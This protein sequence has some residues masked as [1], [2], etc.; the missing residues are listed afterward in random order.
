MSMGRCCTLAESTELGVYFN[1]WLWH[2][3]T[4]MNKEQNMIFYTDDVW[5]NLEVSGKACVDLL[6]AGIMSIDNYI[7]QLHREAKDFGVLLS[8]KR[9]DSK[10]L[11]DRL[12]VYLRK[13]RS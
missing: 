1:L 13:N 9:T 3:E 8:I 11:K 12:Y 2:K 6:R 4:M 10:Y 7:D 5:D